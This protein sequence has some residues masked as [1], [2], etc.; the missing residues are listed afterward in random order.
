MSL[1]I[2]FLNVFYFFTFCFDFQ[3]SQFNHSL[4]F[5][6][7]VQL[8]GDEQNEESLANLAGKFA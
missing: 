8:M 7:L 2:Y 4:L 5:I 3:F 6:F 1:N